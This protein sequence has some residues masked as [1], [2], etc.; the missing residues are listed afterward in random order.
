MEGDNE[1]IICG[2]RFLLPAVPDPIEISFDDDVPTG[3]PADRT[4]APEHGAG[5]GDD[6]VRLVPKLKRYRRKETGAS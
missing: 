1:Y 4:R 2:K 5:K 6:V 3:T